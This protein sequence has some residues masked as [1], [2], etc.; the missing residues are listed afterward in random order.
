MG[1]TRSSERGV[2]E[3]TSLFLMALCSSYQATEPPLS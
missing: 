2:P 1:A 3:G